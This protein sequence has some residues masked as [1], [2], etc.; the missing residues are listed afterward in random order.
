MSKIIDT[1]EKLKKENADKIYL[2]KSGIFYIAVNEDALSLNELFGF[3][4]TDFGTNIKVGFPNNSL[5]KYIKKFE[6]K[7]IDFQIID[8]NKKIE[9]NIDYL[10]EEKCKNILNEI[11]NMDLN[12]VSPIK[13]FQK[14]YDYQ[15]IIKKL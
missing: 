5:N 11:K 13:A 15:N 12:G 14:L 10:N 1:Y 4:L 8:N 3:S 7:N 6:D 9:N 2:F